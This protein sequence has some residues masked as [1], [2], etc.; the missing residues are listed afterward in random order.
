MD[1][2]LTATVGRDCGVVFGEAWSPSSRYLAV[3]GPDPGPHV[4]NLATGH[5]ELTISY[6]QLIS[7]LDWAPAGDQLVTGSSAGEVIVFDASSGAI[8]ARA[9]GHTDEVRTVAFSPDGRLV[10]S[11]ANDGTVRIWS[12]FDLSP[13]SVIAAHG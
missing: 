1:A 5:A 11:G 13:L 7:C 12:A 3:A 6:P 8:S 2:Q 4:W 10:A 9:I